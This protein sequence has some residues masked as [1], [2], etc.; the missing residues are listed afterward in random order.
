MFR[1][2]FFFFVLSFFSQCASTQKIDS[3]PPVKIIEA[4]SQSW[5]AGVR[6]GGSGTN[7][8]LTFSETI[9]ADSLYYQG[10]IAKLRP[11]QD[12]SAIK[13]VARFSFKK[14]T[15]DDLVMHSDPLKEYGNTVVG[16]PS[17]T[18][19]FELKKNQAV[20]SYKKGT[21][22]RYFKVANI[23]ELKQKL[24]PSRPPSVKP[25]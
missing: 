24:F 25:Q 11:L 2:I 9:A 4:Q 17:K 20:V 10:M 3:E 5:V 12:P 13:Y 6:G 15:Q 1:A 16:V 7:V 23:V 21:K 8:F 22:T 18:F 14:N 19:P